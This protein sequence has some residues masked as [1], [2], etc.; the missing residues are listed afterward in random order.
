MLKVDA[1]LNHIPAGREHVVAL[2]ESINQPLVNIPG[3]GTAPTFAYILGTRNKQGHLTVFVYLYQ[4][5]TGAVVVYVCEPRS[6]SR[7]QYRAEEAEAVRFVESMGFLVDN[8]HFP[9]LPPH[10]QDA[11]MQRA[12]LFR[13]PASGPRSSPAAV[14]RSGPTST[15]R[16]HEAPAS[17][18]RDSDALFGGLGEEESAVFR[19]AGL[20][21]PP[22]P[23]GVPADVVPGS[24]ETPPPREVESLS[25]EAK[26]RLGRLFGMFAL[27]VGVTL[28]GC[29]TG[30]EANEEPRSVDSHIDLGN[31]QLARGLW[32][33][34]VRTFETVL[35][36]DEDNKEALRG[37]GLAYLNLERL[38]EAETYYRRSIESDPKWSMPRNE[39]AIVLMEK[40]DCREAQTQLEQVLKDIFYPTPEFA[41]HNLAKAL[42]CQGDAQGAMKKLEELVMKRPKFCLGYLTLAEISFEAKAHETTIE[43]CDG[44]VA[45]CE[46]DERIREQILPE[47]RAKC[48][49]R[50]G[51]A[52]AALG[53]VESAR[54]AFERCDS[55]GP[56]GRECRRSLELLPP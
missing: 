27:L 19:R 51:M 45:N 37:L 49:L 22:R 35:E 40:G 15:P 26:A 13:P 9:T 50:K 1:S 11:V 23:A 42:A 33:D 32:P 47:H 24:P 56:N 48:Y 12:P 29:R 44:F 6:L 38:E 5:Q 4:Q 25:S 30:R 18:P 21:G 8:V 54:A 2:Y 3:H 43:A 36:A 52:Y 14:P 16:G 46:E 55:R 34:A 10:E 17:S 41:E 28:P 7:E 39:L 20:S 53:D 31:Q